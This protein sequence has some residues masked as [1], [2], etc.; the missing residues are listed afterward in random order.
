[1]IESNDIKITK[2]DPN[3]ITPSMFENKKS[4]EYFMIGF[5]AMRELQ[6]LKD[7][8]H[9]ISN[10][11][12]P[13]RDYENFHISFDVHKNKLMM[14]RIGLYY[15]NCMTMWL[16]A[17]MGNIPDTIFVYKKELTDAFAK[18]THFRPRE[19]QKFKVKSIEEYLDL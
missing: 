9:I 10:A 6:E 7:K 14:P 8:S 15:N 5:Y 18:I 11:G 1:M 13:I 3:L 12:E 4:Y 16:G 17:T 2:C 19:V